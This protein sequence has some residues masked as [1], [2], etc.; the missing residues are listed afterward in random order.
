MKDSKSCPNCGNEDPQYK[1]SDRHRG[2]YS[3]DCGE[4]IVVNYYV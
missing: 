4:R 3:C 2:Y 1:A